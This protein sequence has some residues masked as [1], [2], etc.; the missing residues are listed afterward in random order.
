MVGAGR[1]LALLR[2]CINLIYSVFVKVQ[3]HPV[4]E[5]LLVKFVK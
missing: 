5:L 2:H 4:V 3:K 1:H